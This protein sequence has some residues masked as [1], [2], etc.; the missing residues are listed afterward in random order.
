MAAREGPLGAE[1]TGPGPGPP[2]E[3]AWAELR[4]ALDEQVER[5]PQKYREA[6]VLRCLAGKSAEDAAR[7]LGCPPATV[8]SRLARARQRLRERLAARGFGPSAALAGAVPA[9][10]VVSEVLSAALAAAAGRAAAG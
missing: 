3:A 9:A 10:S 7:E 5:L 4:G 1:P 6:F 2:E 8:E